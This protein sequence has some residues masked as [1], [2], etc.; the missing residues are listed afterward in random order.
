VFEEE[1]LPAAHPLW[2]TPNVFIS[3]H[4]AAPSFPTDIVGVFADNYRRYA[5]HEPLRY[6]VDFDRG[7]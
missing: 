1:P 7:Y 5:R 4:T 6:R 3:A 2:R